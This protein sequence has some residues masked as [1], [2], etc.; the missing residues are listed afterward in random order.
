[1][2]SENLLLV[3]KLL[4]HRP[5]ESTAGYGHLSVGCLVKSAEKTGIIF[6]CI[7]LAEHLTLPAKR[8]IHHETVPRYSLAEKI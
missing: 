1:M 2:S 4:D 5:H 3:G 6:T 7:M 8:R